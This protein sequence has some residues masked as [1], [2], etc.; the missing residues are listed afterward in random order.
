MTAADFET[1]RGY[2]KATPVVDGDP[3]GSP[4]SVGQGIAYINAFGAAAF[5]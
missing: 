4:P 3:A 5:G 1:M 2:W